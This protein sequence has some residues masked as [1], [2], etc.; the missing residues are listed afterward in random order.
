[1]VRR[2]QD[3]VVGRP[4]LETAPETRHRP[5]VQTRVLW[6]RMENLPKSWT[7]G[8]PNV[9]LRRQFM[10]DLEGGGAYL[11]TLRCRS[12]PHGRQAPSINKPLRYIQEP[13]H[14]RRDVVL[15]PH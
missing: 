11:G 13:R 3:H 6:T 12:G 8:A 14:G 10:L 15:V 1:M 9:R 5:G 4:R 7:A 2:G